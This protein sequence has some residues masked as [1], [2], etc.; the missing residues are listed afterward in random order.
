MTWHYPKNLVNLTFDLSALRIALTEPLDSVRFY[1]SRATLIVVPA[2]LVDHWKNQIER[3]VKPGQLRVYVWAD[4][5]KPSV[6]NIAWDYDVVIT[7]FSR[8]SAE[9]SPKKRSVLMQV[10]WLRV[11]FDEGHTL[12]SSLNLTNK[13]QLSVSLTASSRWLLTG[14]P[15]PNTPNSQLSNLQPM[16]KFLREEA[17]G[18]N[19]RSWDSGILRPFEAKM[20][21]GRARLL[22]L[23]RRCMISARKKDLLMIPPCIKKVTLINFNGEH[24]KTYNELVVTVRRNILMADWND[25]SH[26]E[27]LLNPKQWKFRSTLIRNVRLSCCVAGHIKVTDAGEDIQETMD[28][29]VENGLDPL[30]EEYAFIRYNILFGGNCMR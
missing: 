5:K 6:H 23:L 25:P 11:V 29:L 2:N 16:L 4:H 1:L 28:I 14:T 27:S 22:Q 20:E 18:L 19:Q 26:V 9:W 15:T 3:H 17:Y 24:A 13:L 30:S 8:L 7:T 12:G 10:H 21:E